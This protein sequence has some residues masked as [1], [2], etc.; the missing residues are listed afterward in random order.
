MQKLIVTKFKDG[1]LIRKSTK[2]EG[3]GTM[4]IIETKFKFNNGIPNE[5]KRVAFLRGEIS[6]LVKDFGLKEGD[7]LNAKLASLGH[8]GVKIVRKES[9]TPFFVGQQPKINP[10]NKE[11][12]KDTAGNPIYL[13]DSIVDNTSAEEDE[14]LAGVSTASVIAEAG[15]QA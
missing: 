15:D 3:W 7:D 13:Q 12:V 9:T 4:M 14:L 5:I 8:C 10:Q 2:K 1:Q 6:K 11:V